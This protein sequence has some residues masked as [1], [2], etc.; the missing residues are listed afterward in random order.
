[1]W[2]TPCTSRRETDRTRQL[3]DRACG[4]ATVITSPTFDDVLEL[5]EHAG[6][7]VLHIF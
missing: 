2:N 1:M 6:D 7:D 3:F 5:D 4:A